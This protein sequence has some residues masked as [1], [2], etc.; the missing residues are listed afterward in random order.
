[1]KSILRFSSF[2]YVAALDSSAAPFINLNFDSANTNNLTQGLG[3]T[4]DLLPGW[5][6]YVQENPANTIGLN[7]VSRGHRSILYD[8]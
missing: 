4:S 3:F 1:M 6:L 5:A 2:Y 7:L 8:F